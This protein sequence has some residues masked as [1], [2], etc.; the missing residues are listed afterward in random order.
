MRE[1]GFIP[2]TSL[3]VIIL[4]LS[5]SIVGYYHWNRHQAGMRQIKDSG[6]SS[7]VTRVSGKRADIQRHA[8]GALNDALWKAG[9]RTSIPHKLRENWAEV[10]AE[11]NL[12]KRLSHLSELPENNAFNPDLE[13]GNGILDYELERKGEGYPQAR[14]RLPK[15][16]SIY[17]SLPDN[18]ISLEMPGE[19]IET[20]VN[21]RFYLMMDRMKKFG[22]G[23]EKIEYRWM[24]AEYALA[25]AQAWG[26]KKLSLN[27]V[28]SRALFQL[29]LASHEIDKFGSTDYLAIA[30]KLSGIP[31]GNRI[32]DGYDPKVVVQPIRDSE[33]ENLKE[34][35]GNSKSSIGKSGRQ[36]KNSMLK[37][38][39]AKNFRPDEFLSNKKQELSSLRERADE[40]SL[41]S[42]KKEFRGICN[43][44]RRGYS[45][46]EDRAEDAL[47]EIEKAEKSAE[48]SRKKFRNAIESM[49]RLSKKN[50]MM[51][52]LYREFTRSSNNPCIQNQIMGGT[53]DVLENIDYIKS[54]LRRSRNSLQSPDGVES[55]FPG[56]FYHRFKDASN[57]E[58][59]EDLKDIIS[60]ASKS[61]TSA[62]REFEESIREGLEKADSTC[63]IMDKIVTRQLKT[64]KSNWEREYE[65]YPDPGDDYK[66]TPEKE[67]A[68]KYVIYPGKRTI[69]GLEKVIGNAK[70]HIEKLSALGNEFEKERKELKEFELDKNLK[71]SLKKDMNRK[72]LQNF[73]R[74]ESYELSPPK[75]LR[76]NP[77]LSVYYNLEIEEVSY[78]RE[79]PV[80]FVNESIPTPI[81]LWFINTTLYW[82]QWNVEIKLGEPI[83]EEVFDYKNKNILRPL[84]EGS[85]IH[86]HKPLPYRQKF[87]KSEFSFRLVVLSLRPFEISTG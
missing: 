34:K 85:K 38:R 44:F 15:G 72:N 51:K 7:L 9:K 23:L 74:E 19:I 76:S 29:S 26:G 82:A 30:E 6:N 69:G 40:A 5:V 31:G 20:K 16:T 14:V 56:N 36:L 70:S 53:R 83:V 18:S 24:F 59:R 28:R 81:Y 63:Q 75:P 12:K 73:T 10:I 13:L 87:Q 22:K 60:E 49:E 66:E 50:P 84:S 39:K 21:S 25:Y 65:K 17:G 45:Y 27:K 8:L 67:T 43:E 78:N 61:A 77:G 42:M 46:P 35:L 3:G 48:N 11:M 37:I 54:K 68:R 71:K 79:N 4:V 62:F 80:G 58:N 57:R 1:K 47:K 52:Q 41:Q 64:P 32:I 86:V 33:I 55:K 2:L